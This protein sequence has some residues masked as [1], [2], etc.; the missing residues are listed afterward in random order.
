MVATRPVTNR[1]RKGTRTWQRQE[2][3][4]LNRFK[5]LKK[6]KNQQSAAEL[7]ATTWEVI[8][9]EIQNK[10]AALG[11]GPPPQE[12]PGLAEILQTHLSALPQAVQDVVNKLNQPLP[13]TEKELA[14][15]LKTQ[16]TE[17]KTIS[18]KKAQLQMK[19]RQTK[20]QY[21]AMLQDMQEHQTRLNEGQQKLKTLSEQYMQAVNKTPFPAALGTQEEPELPIPMAVEIFVNSLG[22]TLTEEQR[23]Q[24][25][26]L[27]K[28]PGQEADEASKRRKTESTASPVPAGQCG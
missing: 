9:S 21:A 18:M 5:P 7:L 12:E 14:Q 17:L 26:G 11:L 10:L 19:L 23:S 1:Q 25:H 6:T 28:R 27:L 24:L 13:D 4:E 20:S 3:H 8:P 2:L 15:K 22:L 16:V